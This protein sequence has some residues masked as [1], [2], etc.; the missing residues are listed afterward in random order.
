[1]PGGRNV[2]R[3][4]PLADLGQRSKATAAQRLRRVRGILLHAVQA[5][6]AAALAWYVAH[7][8]VGHGSPFFAPI[9]AVVV[10]GVSVGQRFRRAV[11]LV[12]GVALGILLGD[13]LFS[14][15]G[16]GPW[17]IGLGV[18]LAISCAVFLGGSAMLVSQAGSSAVLV[19][20]LA[21]PA[22]GIY[23][24]RFLDALIGGTAGVLVMA[25]LLPVNPLTLVRKAAVPLFAVLAGALRDCADALARADR[26]A[27]QEVLERLRRSETVLGQ[28]RDALV[29]AQEAVTLAPA[30]WRART[31]LAQYRDSAVHVDRAVRNGRVLIRR[32]VALLR[33]G[34]PVPGALPAALGTLAEAVEALSRDLA[35]GREPVPARE[36]CVWAVAQAGDAYRSGLGFSGTVVVA[37]VRSMATDLLRASGIEDRLAE[38][39]VRRAVGK[40]GSGTAGRTRW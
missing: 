7:D 40:L 13:A 20:T 4:L 19:A 38:R 39:A 37:Q 1:L 5:G 10:L 17:Q 22:Q 30:R 18:V 31:P 23:Y 26:D 29:T 6:T 15:I 11:E 28:F 32:A 27:A 8:L 34:E 9:S 35:G 12:L 36:L 3:R 2:L 24:T 25:L 16:T 21:P 33:D 14:L